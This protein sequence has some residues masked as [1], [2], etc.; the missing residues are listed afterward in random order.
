[1]YIDAPHS[2]TNGRNLKT[3]GR[4]AY[5]VGYRAVQ[6]FVIVDYYDIS[7]NRLSVWQCFV[8]SCDVTARR[9]T[10]SE[11]NRRLKPCHHA[12]QARRTNDT[13]SEP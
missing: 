7:H 2:S 12:R 13:F 1:M 8:C 4:A 10:E 11:V 6:L 3:G 5:R 9:E